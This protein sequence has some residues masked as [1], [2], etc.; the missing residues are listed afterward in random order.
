[1]ESKYYFPC[2]EGL[3]ELQR[4]GADKRARKF[5]A[6]RDAD[7]RSKLHVHIGLEKIVQVVQQ[8]TLQL[9]LTHEIMRENFRVFVVFLTSLLSTGCMEITKADD[10]FVRYLPRKFLQEE[11]MNS[12]CRLPN[13]MSKHLDKM[14]TNLL[15]SIFENQPTLSFA[16]AMRQMYTMGVCHPSLL[17]CFG[18]QFQ[19][20]DVSVE[21][22]SQTLLKSQTTH[23][24][25][26]DMIFE[27]MIRS[28]KLFQESDVLETNVG[29][30]DCNGTD[31]YNF[32]DPHWYA[33]MAYDKMVSDE[34]I[35]VH[36]TSY[37]YDDFCKTEPKS[38]SQS[39]I[40]RK[41]RK[42]CSL[43]ETSLHYPHSVS[44]QS[45]IHTLQLSVR[46]STIS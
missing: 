20:M 28:N 17:C 15:I 22:S 40:Q 29:I 25:V 24:D 2:I 39:K 46:A 11:Q 27:N 23:N 43:P 4:E 13:V 18:L 37:H 8:G 7:D 30:L 21:I 26:Y 33:R 44:K 3:I 12:K 19:T 45:A 31:V 5:F 9:A 32:G 34:G 16:D 1:M 10:A 6:W 14:K 35:I 41:V 42:E 36:A 38:T